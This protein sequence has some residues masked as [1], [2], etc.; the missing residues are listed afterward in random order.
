MD[1]AP[2]S[3]PGHEPR[4][5]HADSGRP[6][7]RGRAWPQTA[8]PSLDD[9]IEARGVSAAFVASTLAQLTDGLKRSASAS[10]VE[11][12]EDKV[13][14]TEDEV[15]AA[16][17]WVLETRH[18]AAGLTEPAPEP[19]PEPDNGTRESEW[20]PAEP[21]TDSGGRDNSRMSQRLSKTM[22]R[23]RTKDNRSVAE[24]AE[25]ELRVLERGLRLHR[26][27]LQRRKR[28]PYVSARDVHRELI[29][30]A[31]KDAM[32]RYVELPGVCDGH[33]PATGQW[34][35]GRA[36]CFLSYSWDSPWEEVVSALVSHTERTVAA[37]YP[38][39]YY[40]IDIFAVNQH[41]SMRPWTCPGVG[42]I[43]GCPG[44][45]AVHE[46]MHD[47]SRDVGHPAKGFERVIQQTKHT[48]VLMEPW[49]SPRP[50]TRVWCLFECYQ[51]L[52]NGG[53]LEVALGAQQHHHLTRSLG[54][55]FTE[56]EALVSGIDARL[57]E[58]TMED[59][60]NNIFGLISGAPGGFNALN[61]AIRTSL[62]QWLVSSGT[63]L[64]HRVDP[65]APA[66]SAV[67]LDAEVTRNRYGC[68]GAKALSIINWYPRLPIVLI[69][70]SFITCAMILLAAFIFLYNDG[71]LKH[72]LVG[73]GCGLAFTTIEGLTG[74]Q[75]YRM[76]FLHRLRSPSPFAGGGVKWLLW[77]T[78][79]YAAYGIWL[80]VFF[81][82]A[83]FKATHAVFLVLG[84]SAAVCAYPVAA[85]L[86]LALRAYFALLSVRIGWVLLKLRRY[87]TA[88]HLFSQANDVFTKAIGPDTAAGFLAVPGLVRAYQLLGQEDLADM[89]YR[90]AMSAVEA[91][92][93]TCRKCCMNVLH[94]EGRFN[95]FWRGGQPLLDVL[96]PPIRIDAI[97]ADGGSSR[98]SARWKWL[99]AE[100]LSVADRDLDE[101]VAVLS[102]AVGDGVCFP[103]ANSPA[104]DR[105][106]RESAVS[107][108]PRGV[109]KTSPRVSMMHHLSKEQCC[110]LDDLNAAITSNQ[111]R[112]RV[113]H[114]SWAF[115]GTSLL[116]GLVLLA[117]AVGEG[118]L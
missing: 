71:T 89:Q 72:A 30:A 52:A 41:L 29:V 40:W 17:E 50:P 11:F 74:M 93:R 111:R 28:K 7:L 82:L 31:T 6:K 110:E 116:V 13:K 38:P 106:R 96:M 105:I 113:S 112:A 26:E 118:L 114:I 69:V 39:P 42:L 88:L 87:D 68:C 22:S 14:Q 60:R 84:I 33:D 9:G 98:L 86:D 32:C 77:F 66:L 78:G 63:D 115:V 57:A 73:S 49:D 103:V 91:G 15:Q 100:L 2:P 19:E 58:A 117:I 4:A 24:Q 92:L 25:Q 80:L 27:D 54:E 20:A 102:D 109:I 21:E 79:I 55:R 67:E 104:F 5:G 59:D 8:P 48:L 51:T 64:L 53:K 12:L 90:R 97:L 65:S 10:A 101:V 83:V 3:G 70:A 56:L 45:K 108:S 35:V 62:L 94:E 107:M 85:Y 99:Q 81:S 18:T 76:R 1:G 23:S 36:Q 43:G 47:W 61:E 46:D 44:C 34:H 16:Q 95:W 75:L 37:G